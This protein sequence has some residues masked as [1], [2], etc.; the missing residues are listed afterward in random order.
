MATEPSLWTLFLDP[1]RTQ[2]GKPEFCRIGIGSY[3]K[4]P[5][6]TDSQLTE[7]TETKQGQDILRTADLK[8]DGVEP[9]GVE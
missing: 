6:T 8:Q 9:S 3:E 5:G 1:C 7:E 2:T 4:D